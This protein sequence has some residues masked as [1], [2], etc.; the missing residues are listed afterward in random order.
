MTYLEELFSIRGKL[1]VITGGGG[2]IAGA[3]AEALLRAGA[4]LSLWGRGRP[5]LDAAVKRLSPLDPSGEGWA[6]K[7]STPRTREV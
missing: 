2:V 3:L 5:S 7:S 6:L 4:A 1:V